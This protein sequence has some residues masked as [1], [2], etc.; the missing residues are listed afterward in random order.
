MEPRQTSPKPRRKRPA[1]F[2]ILRPQTSA[3]DGF[4]ITDPDYS[5]N[6]PHTIKDQNEPRDSL[7][8]QAG[9]AGS[10]LAQKT[11]TGHSIGQFRVGEQN[12]ELNTQARAP[13]GQDAETV[14]DNDKDS[15]LLYGIQEHATFKRSMESIGESQHRESDQRQQQSRW[16]P[17]SEVDAADAAAKAEDTKKKGY[18]DK[19]AKLEN[20]I[21]AQKDEH[22]KREAAADAAR[23]AAADAA[24][25]E[26]KQIAE[27]KKIAASAVTFPSTIFLDS[28]I[29]AKGTAPQ[30]DS[31]KGKDVPPNARWTRL[32]RRLV[33]PEALERAQE[34]FE[35]HSDGVMVLRVL[36][37]DEIQRLADMTKQIREEREEEYA[38]RPSGHNADMSDDSH[39]YTDPA[40]MYRDIEPAWR[41]PRAEPHRNRPS[42]V[43]PLGKSTRELG[44]P[45]SIR[46]Y[47]K[48]NAGIDVESDKDERAQEPSVQRPTLT[49]STTS[50]SEKSDMHDNVNKA[51]YEWQCCY[52]GIPN[53]PYDTNACP[54][55]G[56]GRCPQCVVGKFGRE[57]QLYR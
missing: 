5:R 25:A 33:N 50:E 51:M 21:W 12:I 23:K 2:G 17:S 43:Q 55:C 37:R 32:D 22:L 48:I 53:L 1:D 47:D 6:I 14:V 44:P 54:H 9:T 36:T 26:A 24:D 42:N 18:E 46:V 39:S 45:P 8:I 28:E 31:V 10:V 15:Q 40:S 7:D 19:L 29:G 49:E 16:N 41:R 38:S 13:T 20:L 27:E 34:R 56:Y 52:C 35:E 30:Q 4:T 57:E 3:A 11:T